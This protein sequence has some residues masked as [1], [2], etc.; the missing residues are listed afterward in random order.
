VRQAAPLI[1]A[2]AE[3]RL[4]LVLRFNVAYDLCH[5]GLA[6]EVEPTLPE[7]EALVTSLGNRLDLVRFH[8]LEGTVAAARGRTDE[9][10]AILQQVRADFSS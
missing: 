1:D 10:I 7:L 5:L 9:A 2:Q 4:P 6:A 3:P 8:G